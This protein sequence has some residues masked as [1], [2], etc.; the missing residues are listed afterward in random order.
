MR[1][2]VTDTETTGL[3]HEKDG[4]VEI[5]GACREGDSLLVY[6]SFCNP[7]TP[8]SV[9]AMATHHITEDM[10]RGAKL[11]RD[12]LSQMM[13]KLEGDGV[14]LLVA[15]N[16]QFDRGFIGKLSLKLSDQTRW[17]C[18]YRCAMHLWPDAPGHSNQV[19]RYWLD[20]KPE[21]PPGLYPHRALYDVMVT[22]AILRRMLETKSLEELVELSQKPVLLSKV[23]FGKH[24]GMFWKDVPSDYLRWILKQSD[25][26]TDVRHTAYHYATGQTRLI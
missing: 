9:E 1:Y 23:R 13:H 3:D 12:A 14:T 19:L 17:I 2:I 20:V 8:I 11:P 4:I 16:A 5:A 18:T 15:H 25:I 6:E 26:D 22:E 7:G 10:V 24:K 21:L